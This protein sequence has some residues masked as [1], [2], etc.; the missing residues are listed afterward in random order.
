[1]RNTSVYR[2]CMLEPKYLIF[3]FYP[4]F[5]KNKLSILFN[6]NWRRGNSAWPEMSRFQPSTQRRLAF[7]AINSRQHF[8]GFKLLVVMTGKSAFHA[9]PF[10]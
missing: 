8:V 3:L 2:L 10:V 4:A 6:F 5:D 1:M 9:A 7:Q